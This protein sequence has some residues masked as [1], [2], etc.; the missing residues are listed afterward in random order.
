MNLRKKK[1]LA[2]RLLKVGKDRIKFVS[3]RITEI[4]EA[5]TKQDIRDFVKE[6]IIV[7]KELRGRRGK[8]RWEMEGGRWEMGR[9][10]VGSEKWEVVSGW[11]VRGG[12][13][14]SV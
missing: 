7:V 4:K 10:E 12:R 9:W 13:L 5:I 3:E 11:R 8:G 14:S 6:N 2:A 1:I